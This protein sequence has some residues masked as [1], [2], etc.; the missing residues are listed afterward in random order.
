MT[1]PAEIEIP[2]EFGVCADLDVLV[3]VP[4]VRDVTNGNISDG[5]FTTFVAMVSFYLEDMDE[6]GNVRDIT[7]EELAKRRGISKRTLQ[8]HLAQLR[9]AGWILYDDGALTLVDRRAA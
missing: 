8:G 3:P 2:E 9:D 6:D 5:A 1:T 7:R 4:L